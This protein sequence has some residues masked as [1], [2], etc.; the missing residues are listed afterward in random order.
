MLHL[1][2]GSGVQLSENNFNLQLYDAAARKIGIGGSPPSVTA[3][4]ASSRSEWRWAAWLAGYEVDSYVVTAAADVAAVSFFE[5]RGATLTRACAA[6]GAHAQPVRAQRCN[7]YIVHASAEATCNVCLFALVQRL[8]GVA[9]E[10]PETCAALV[11]RLST[12]GREYAIKDF[13]TRCV[14]VRTFVAGCMDARGHA[15][16]VCGRL[17]AWALKAADRMRKD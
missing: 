2:R 7:L 14:C 15:A 11:D 1:A 13:K 8:D 5:I 12:Y 16:V 9:V 3:A 6:V 10:S 17:R 4:Y